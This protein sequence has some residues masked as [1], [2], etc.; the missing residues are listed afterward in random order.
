MKTGW[1]L[2]QGQMNEHGHYRKFFIKGK[3]KQGQIMV[4]HWNIHNTVTPKRKNSDRPWMGLFAFYRLPKSFP[5]S[6]LQ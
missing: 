3:P 4:L 6:D 2:I 5:N 1:I